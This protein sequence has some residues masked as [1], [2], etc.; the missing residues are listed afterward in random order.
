MT[1]NNEQPIQVSGTIRLFQI[2]AIAALLMGLS[3]AYLGWR[4][5]Q[6]GATAPGK[7]VGINQYPDPDTSDNIGDGFVYAE[8]VEFTVAGETHTFENPDRVYPP[9]HQVGEAVRVRYDPNDLTVAVIDKWVD[10]WS[11]P[12]AVIPAMIAALIGLN[13]YSKRTLV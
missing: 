2:L 8:M 5:E 13:L 4:D 10:R 11:F 6:V 9:A 1:E 12:V 3:S 7:V